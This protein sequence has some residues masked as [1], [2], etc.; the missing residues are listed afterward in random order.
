VSKR[1]IS[2]RLRVGLSVLGQDLNLWLGR[3]WGEN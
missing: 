1:N 3:F 2:A